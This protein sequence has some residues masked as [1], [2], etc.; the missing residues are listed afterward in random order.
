MA[1]LLI[2]NGFMDHASVRVPVD[3]AALLFTLCNQ[4]NNK[5]NWRK[6]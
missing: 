5:Y 2:D 3:V 6:E 1:I 4:F